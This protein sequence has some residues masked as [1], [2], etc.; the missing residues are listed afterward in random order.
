MALGVLC[1]SLATDLFYAYLDP[2]IRYT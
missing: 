2:K 1:S